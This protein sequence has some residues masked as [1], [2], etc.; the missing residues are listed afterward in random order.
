MFKTDTGGFGIGF[1]RIGFAE[2]NKDLDS[3]VSYAKEQGFACI[4]LTRDAD[5]TGKKVLDAGLEIG[6]VDLPDWQGL[7]SVDKKVRAEAVEKNSAYIETCSSEG[8]KNFFVVIQPADKSIPMKESFDAALEGYRELGPV[9]EAGD[10]WVVVEGCPAMIS[11]PETYRVFLK[12]CHPRMAINYDPSH[13][14]RMGI[15]PIRF[16]EE[17]ASRVKHIHGKDTEITP[18]GMYEFGHQIQPVLSETPRCGSGYWRYTI[19]G[20]GCMRWRK[21]FQILEKAG[22]KGKIS[23]EHE[24]HYFFDGEDRQK[25]GLMAGANFLS[26]C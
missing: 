20:H 16:L 12:E 19:P 5:E 7:T 2:W 9:L 21:A 14:I 24:D 10:A 6:S 17:F 8:M 11:T 23:I 1:R 25:M 3:V 26:S 13:L 18:E 15:D 4:D 22:Y